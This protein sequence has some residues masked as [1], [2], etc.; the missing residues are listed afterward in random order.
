MTSIA[1]CGDSFCEITSDEPF[2]AWT[3]LLRD[4]YDAHILCDGMG[5]RA[6]IHSYEKLLPVIDDADYVIFCITDP[7]R[8]PNRDAQALTINPPRAANPL[9]EAAFHY[10]K[11]IFHENYHSMAQIGILMQMD[12]LMIQKQKK[13]IWFPCFVNSMQGYMPQSGP[14]SNIHLGDISYKELDTRWMHRERLE[15]GAYRPKPPMFTHAWAKKVAHK[16][17]IKKDLY[18]TKCH[19]NEKN[20]ICMANVVIDIIDSDDFSSRTIAMEDYFNG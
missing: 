1:F 16:D 4:R 20:N 13:C 12:Q 18:I 11:H 7:N 10:Y 3:N 15:E 2:G 6:L 8:L 19:M 9:R 14:I 17:T 5:G